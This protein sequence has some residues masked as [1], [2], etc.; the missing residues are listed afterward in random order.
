MFSFFFQSE[1]QSLELTEPAD[2]IQ[3]SKEYIILQKNHT[4]TSLFNATSAKQLHRI[5]HSINQL[6]PDAQLSV[7]PIGHFDH[8]VVIQSVGVFEVYYLQN[9][10]K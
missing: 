1:T 6:T 3:I 2:T 4:I 7:K 10:K 9:T 8:A 5:D